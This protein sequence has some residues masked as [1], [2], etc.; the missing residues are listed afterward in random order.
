[1][2]LGCMRSKDS[3]LAFLAVFVVVL[4]WAPHAWHFVPMTALALLCGAKADR[5]R[6]SLLT[7]LAAQFLTDLGLEAA[8]RLG[9]REWPGF[10]SDILAV[11]GSLLLITA[12]GW[13]LR[14]RDNPYSLAG[15]ANLT[16]GIVLS[17]AVFYLVTNFSAWYGSPWYPQTLMGLQESYVAGLPFLRSSAAGDLAY[18]WGFFGCWAMAE[19]WLRGRAP[20]TVDG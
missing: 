9:W 17:T 10:H 13:L 15:R 8:H 14:G 4:R 12:I 6:W 20:A 18:G 2:T 7:P 1:M 19:Q 3:V 11:Y 5:K 16:A